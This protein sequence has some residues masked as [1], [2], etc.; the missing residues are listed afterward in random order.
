MSTC[1]LSA[2]AALALEDIYIY[3]GNQ[4]GEIQADAYHESFAK[5]F[6]L[7]T[8]FPDM[9]QSA[10]EYI[11]SMR[12]FRHQSHLIFYNLQRDQITIQ[13]ILHAKQDV[14]KHMLDD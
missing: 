5:M 11:A 2:N 4:F 10:D 8:D 12:K 9:G 7:L 14:R 1:K 6:E 3:T 13:H